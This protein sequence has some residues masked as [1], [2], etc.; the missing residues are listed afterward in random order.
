MLE[1]AG[2]IGVAAAPAAALAGAAGAERL[3]A[4]LRLLFPKLWNDCVRIAARIALPARPGRVRLLARRR[5]P[6]Q[7][8]A[9][10]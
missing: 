7:A 4:R 2:A 1:A 8:P 9:V 3:R 5:K 10:P 6:E